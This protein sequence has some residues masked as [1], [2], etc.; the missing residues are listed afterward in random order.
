[1][2]KIEGSIDLDKQNYKT[3]EEFFSAL[4][5]LIDVLTKANYDCL[6]KYE[7]LGIYVIQYCY[8]ENAL[9]GCCDRFVPVTVEEADKISEVS[10]D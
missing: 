7:D 2:G 4:S 1:M 10:D 3:E 8:N 9:D 5:K 6:V